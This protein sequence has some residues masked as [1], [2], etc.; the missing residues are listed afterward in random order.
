MTF[1]THWF[2]LA[3]W[4]HAKLANKGGRPLAWQSSW[5]RFQV[6]KEGLMDIAQNQGGKAGIL[7]KTVVGMSDVLVKH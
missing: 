4:I 5:Q 6:N 1:V 7:P 2:V 3:P